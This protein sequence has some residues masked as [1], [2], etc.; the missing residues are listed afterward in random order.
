VRWTSSKEIAEGRELPGIIQ[1]RVRKISIVLGANLLPLLGPD[2]MG[3]NLE[4]S[5]LN[6]AWGKKTKGCFSL[7]KTVKSAMFK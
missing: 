5:V 3:T 7:T 1:L 6:E 4:K 2:S